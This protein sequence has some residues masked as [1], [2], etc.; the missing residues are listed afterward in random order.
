M[1]ATN[2]RSCHLSIATDLF[3]H[4]LTV[5]DVP[6]TQLTDAET[7][8][9]SS[10]LYIARADRLPPQT[11]LPNPTKTTNVRVERGKLP[12]ETTV[13]SSSTSIILQSVQPFK[14]SPVNTMQTVRTSSNPFMQILYKFPSHA[15]LVNSNLP[16]SHKVE[17][18]KSERHHL[19]L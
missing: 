17:H 16:T 6:T 7:P 10:E 11:A 5:Y 8:Q 2:W 18:V 13:E 12:L 19:L 3:T 15:K 14:Q 9:R 1:T 4:P